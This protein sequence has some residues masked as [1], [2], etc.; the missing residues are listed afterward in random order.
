[1]ISFFFVSL[2]S[3]RDF[4][5]IEFLVFFLIFLLNLGGFL[6]IDIYSFLFNFS[7]GL[8]DF[9]YQSHDFKHLQACYSFRLRKK[10]IIIL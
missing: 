7:F 8:E 4:L 10:A 2:S 1:M 3:L 9:F 5:L 6:L